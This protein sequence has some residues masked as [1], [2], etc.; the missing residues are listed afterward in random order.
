MR[1]NLNFKYSTYCN[2]KLSRIRG[3]SYETLHQPVSRQNYSHKRTNTNNAI[4][5]PNIISA[6]SYCLFILLN[7]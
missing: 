6:L 4:S 5:I 7:T 3:D 2:Y 1:L